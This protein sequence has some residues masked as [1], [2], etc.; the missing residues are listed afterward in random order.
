MT[1]RHFVKSGA[2]FIPAVVGRAKAQSFGIGNVAFAGTIKK[3]VSGLPTPDLLTEDCE[4][5]QN[6]W[7]T[8]SGSPNYAYTPAIVGSFSFGLLSAAE[9]S[10]AFTS[11]TE[12][13][14]FFEIKTALNVS[15]AT[16][17]ELFTTGISG[18]SQY[19][20]RLNG[21]GGGPPNSVLTVFDTDGSH[22]VSGTVQL[23]TGVWYV[24][25]HYKAGSGTNAILTVAYSQTLTEPTSDN[26][27]TNGFATI[28]NGTSTGAVASVDLVGVATTTVFDHIG[29]A[30][31]DMPTGW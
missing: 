25:C 7:T 27:T 30:T 12:A 20:V 28:T 10:K 2:L 21:S 8:Q 13:F 6:G 19:K 23:T 26:G 4:S 3:P 16:I 31:F 15:Q 9:S 1:R 18:N 29:I 11:Q 5:G 22:F 14:V 17:F 24:W